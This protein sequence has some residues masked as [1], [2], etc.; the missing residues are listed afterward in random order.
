MASWPS[1]SPA[2]VRRVLHRRQTDLR[3]KEADASPWNCFL[4]LD[5]LFRARNRPARMYSMDLPRRTM[6]REPIAKITG[7]EEGAT[8]LS[9]QLMP[10][11]SVQL[12]RRF[13]RMKKLGRL[14]LAPEYV[15]AAL[16]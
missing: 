12:P 4:R 13:N 7:V 6:K 8:F 14:F 9:A 3:R 15:K 2:S 11:G 5:S 1:R 10:L 16:R